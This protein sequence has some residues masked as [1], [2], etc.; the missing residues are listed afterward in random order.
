MGQPRH[1]TLIRLRRLG[2]L[3][4]DATRILQTRD[5]YFLDQSFVYVD[6]E[7]GQKRDDVFAAGVP[8]KLA[9][10]ILDRLR[11][12]RLTIPA[13][14]HNPTILATLMHLRIPPCSISGP[15]CQAKFDSPT[16]HNSYV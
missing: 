2:Q 12:A 14:R 6:P 9:Q 7:I 3:P 13:L 4:S 15:I 5:L 11:L 8:A 1:T 16:A 10:S